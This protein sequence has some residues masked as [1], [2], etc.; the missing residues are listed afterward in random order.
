MNFLSNPI[1][2]A[3]SQEYNIQT[4]SFLQGS[5]IKAD[6][7]MQDAVHVIVFVV[8]AE[9]VSDEEYISRLLEMR[10]YARTRGVFGKR[11]PLN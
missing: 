8:P 10:E 7:D 11:H 4:F 6:A 2:S 5:V 3:E 1:L 9:A